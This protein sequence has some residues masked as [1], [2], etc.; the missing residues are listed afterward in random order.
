MSDVEFFEYLARQRREFEEYVDSLPGRRGEQR[1]PSRPS[2][3]QPSPEAVE[4]DRGEA[5]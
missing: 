4:L 3:E 2:G 1:E 5:D